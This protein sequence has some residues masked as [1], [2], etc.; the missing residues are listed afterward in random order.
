MNLEIYQALNLYALRFERVSQDIFN[1]II[2]QAIET[3]KKNHPIRPFLYGEL[4]PAELTPTELKPEP[5]EKYA[6]HASFFKSNLYDPAL[7]REIS[8]FL[9]VTPTLRR[10]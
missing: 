10:T 4:T 3:F 9:W 2:N 7:C 8:D 5:A 6:L 1:Q